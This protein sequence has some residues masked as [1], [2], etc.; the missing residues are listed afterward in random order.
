[1]KARCVRVNGTALEA[2]PLSGDVVKEIKKTGE[3]ANRIDVVFMGDGY[4][5]EQQAQ[6]DKDNQR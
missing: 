3:P 5:A 1:M 4:T 6:M 2:D